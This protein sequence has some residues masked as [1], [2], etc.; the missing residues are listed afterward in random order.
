M[1]CK[2]GSAEMTYF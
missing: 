1:L 2:F